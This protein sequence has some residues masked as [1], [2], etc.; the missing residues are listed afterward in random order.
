MNIL[1]K[2]KTP[3][4]LALSLVFSSQTYAAE[5]DKKVSKDEAPS[6]NKQ[7]EVISIFGSHNQLETATGSAIVIGEASLDL[8][9]FD[10]IHRV[11]QSVPGVYIREEDGY[12]LRPN[13]GLRGATSERIIGPSLSAGRRADPFH[14]DGRRPVLRAGSFGVG[15]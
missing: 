11:L 9:E 10:D 13:I 6:I 7:V 4:F 15:I 12:G 14:H 2:V 5:A 8:Y 3:I 1:F